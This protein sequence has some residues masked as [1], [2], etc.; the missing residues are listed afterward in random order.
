MTVRFVLSPSWPTLVGA[1]LS[2]LS[3]QATTIG[4]ALTWLVDQHPIFGERIFDGERLAPWTIVCLNNTHILDLDT[5]IP[6]G[7]HELQIIPALV[8][9]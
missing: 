6:A 1:D 4:Q 8:G 7:D 9:G 2:E 5:P 3:T